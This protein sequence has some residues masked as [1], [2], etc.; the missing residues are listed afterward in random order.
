MFELQIYLVNTE[1]T[2]NRCQKKRKHDKVEI[3][4]IEAAVS[5]HVDVNEKP[6]PPDKRRE[7]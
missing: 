2:N 5:S 6:V 3:I 1:N 4:C 7:L